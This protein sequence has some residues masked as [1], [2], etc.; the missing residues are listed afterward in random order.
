MMETING[1]NEEEMKEKVKTLAKDNFRTGLNCAESVFKALIDAKLV[2]F[3]PETVSLTTGFGGGIG[4]AGDVCGA[5]AA[6][7]MGI[8]ASHGRRNPTEG[9]MDEKVDQLYG[10]PG[11][12]RFFNQVSHKFAEK[13]GSTQCDELNKEYPDWFQK[14]RFR[15][16][17][18][19]VVDTAGMA[20][21]FIYQGKREGYTQPF[22]KNMAGKV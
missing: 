3:P 2:D 17:M 5:L 1:M 9:T 12:Y 21:E 16:C 11:R 15:K 20:V 10:N 14:D 6:A 4:L 13:F 8:G 19:I 7:V 22:G 18:N